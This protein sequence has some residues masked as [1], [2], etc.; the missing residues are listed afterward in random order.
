MFE[1]FYSIGKCDV[2]IIEYD[3]KQRAHRTTR[4]EVRILI[5]LTD[6]KKPVFCLKIFVVDGRSRDVDM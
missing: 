2:R 6:D 5:E 1:Y 4:C 3:V